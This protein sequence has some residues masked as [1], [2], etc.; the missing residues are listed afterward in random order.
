MR[1]LC[2][3]GRDQIHED[4]AVCV[5]KFDGVHRGHRLLIEKTIAEEKRGL[6]SVALTFRTSPR[7]FLGQENFN[8]VDTREKGILL[9]ETGISYLMQWEFNRQVERMKAEDFLG[10]LIR[11][12]SM[13]TLLVGEDFRFGY[14]GAGDVSLICKLAPKLGYE[15]RIIPKLKEGGEDISS[16]RIRRLIQ[17]GRIEEANSLLGYPFFCY[18]EVIRGRQI[19]RTIGIPTINLSVAEDKL[20]PS[21]GVY[22]TRVL[23]GENAYWGMTNVGVKPTISGVHT[24]GI[25]TYLMDFTGDIYGQEAR[26]DFL[27][28]VRPERKF[29][30][31]AALKD[32][33]GRDRI[34]IESYIS[35]RR[36]H[37]G[38]V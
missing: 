1:Y 37:S 10:Q 2:G 15:A 12:L 28:F 11:D 38:G 8:L 20:L 31:L 13:K 9:E 14:R 33:I 30:N 36:D 3:P 6:R 35:S 23:M 25:E 22:V 18:G 24:P 29:E 27:H 5:G 21:Y 16:S 32:Q 26:V 7:R 19:G 17:E 34:R 4:S